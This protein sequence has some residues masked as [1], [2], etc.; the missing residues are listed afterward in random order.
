MPGGTIQD[1]KWHIQ[2]KAHLLDT[3]LRLVPTNNFSKFLL[4]SGL[5]IAWTSQSCEKGRTVTVACIFHTA[6]KAG[7]ATAAESRILKH[8]NLLYCSVTTVNII[9]LKYT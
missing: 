2:N 9:F 3:L 8:S 6:G 5:E 4:T 1:K 7:E